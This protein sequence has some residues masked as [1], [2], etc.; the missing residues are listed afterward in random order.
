MSESNSL[1]MVILRSISH[2]DFVQRRTWCTESFGSGVEVHSSIQAGLHRWS[3]EL[4]GF[5]IKILYFQNND[6][7]MFYLLKYSSR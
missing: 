6:D 4:V 7:Y 3:Y 5:G 2:R 1:N